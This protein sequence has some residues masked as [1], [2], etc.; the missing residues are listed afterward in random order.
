MCLVELESDMPFGPLG[1]NIQKAVGSIDL[2]LL[3]NDRLEMR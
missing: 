2:K 3:K 1:R